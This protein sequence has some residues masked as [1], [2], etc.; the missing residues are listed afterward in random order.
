MQPQSAC[1]VSHRDS[2]I[3]RQPR[4]RR[5]RKQVPQKP[6]TG[7][8]AKQCSTRVHVCSSFRR[9]DWS[10]VP[11]KGPNRPIQQ[12]NSKPWKRAKLSASQH[13]Q[14]RVPA[15]I[16]TCIAT[17]RDRPLCPRLRTQSGRLRTSHV[18]YL[19]RGT[20]KKQCVVDIGRDSRHTLR[21]LEKSIIHTNSQLKDT[22]HAWFT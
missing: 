3:F 6:V 9:C 7:A 15:C 18:T 8:P 16:H 5:C 14:P 4:S 20:V 10:H 21:K 11:V 13:E 12:R 19:N 2:S 1:A 22:H 17:S